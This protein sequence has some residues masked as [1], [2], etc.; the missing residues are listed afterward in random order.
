MDAL[1][2]LSLPWV[3]PPDW[4]DDG[5]C[6]VQPASSPLPSP[7]LLEH[8]NSVVGSSNAHFDETCDFTNSMP[9]KRGF[10]PN[11]GGRALRGVKH[12]GSTMPT[13]R[14]HICRRAHV[15]SDTL[16][17]CLFYRLSVHIVVVIGD[18]WKLHSPDPIGIGRIR[19]RGG[20][21]HALQWAA[22]FFLCLW[23]T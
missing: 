12:R 23:K 21:V 15:I 19:G 2:P 20:E 16:Y 11:E 7:S 3:P 18:S 10:D 9:G 1:P 8:G 17:G 22:F 6:C 14:V 5:D 4:G 13:K